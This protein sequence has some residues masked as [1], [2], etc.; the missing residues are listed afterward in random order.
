MV[1]PD[2]GPVTNGTQKITVHDLA[3]GLAA[4]LA[5]V[6]VSLLLHTVVPA[7][8]SMTIAVVLGIAAANVPVT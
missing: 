5:A 7:L 6:A 4:A 3:P 1:K 8:P 2:A